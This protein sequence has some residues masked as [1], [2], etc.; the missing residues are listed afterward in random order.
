[1]F[2]SVSSPLASVEA[3]GTH[4]FAKD[5]FPDIFLGWGK[6]GVDGDPM[7]NENYNW[8]GV[9]FLPFILI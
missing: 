2:S 7:V 1:M 6:T 5:T 3:L 8:T 4:H 9:E